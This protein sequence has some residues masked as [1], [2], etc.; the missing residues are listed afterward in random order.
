MYN[1]ILRFIFLFIRIPLMGYKKRQK[2]ILAQKNLFKTLNPNKEQCI[3][4]HCSSLGEYEYIKP[5]IPDLKKINP[6]IKITFFSP[7]GYENFKDFDLVNQILYLPFDIKEKVV[8]FIKTINPIMVIVSKNEIWPNMI[9]YLDQKKIPLF[10][11]GFKI[12]KEKLKNWFIKKYYSKYVPK[13]THVFCQD[14]FTYTFLTLNKILSCSI[15]GNIRINQILKDANIKLEDPVIHRFTQN[16][17]KTIIYGSVEK[18][19]YPII[20]DFIIARKDLNHIIIPHE[21]TGINDLKN[22]LL[23]KYIIYSDKEKDN[24]IDCNIVIVDV[25]GILKHIYQYADIAYIGGGFNQGVHNTLEPAVHGNY[26]F[27]GPNHMNFPETHFFIKNQIANVINNKQEFA[28]KITLL[29]EKDF[30]KEMVLNTT[31]KFLNNNKQD[32]DT[33]IDSINKHLN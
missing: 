26:I 27:F 32:I 15:I 30:S 28:K 12:K 16:N 25:F 10:L 2:W 21:I 7:S 31:A 8:K 22:I 20:I 24:F 18:E 17:K 9:N 1:L 6:L 13:F 14:K 23:S 33:I 19:D 29:L 4:I 3:W 11:I 5:L